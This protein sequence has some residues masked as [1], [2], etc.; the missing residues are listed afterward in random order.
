[1]SI[2]EGEKI[3]LSECAVCHGPNGRMPSAI[4]RSM[5]PETSDLA[6]P[7]VQ[8]YS[9]EQ[10]FWIVKNG[11]RFTGMPGIANF[12]SDEHVWNLVDYIRVLPHTVLP[13]TIEH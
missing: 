6:S 13:H 7:R 8:A 12:E 10:L 9:D 4:G 2:L 11:I 1:M 5:Y 3:Y